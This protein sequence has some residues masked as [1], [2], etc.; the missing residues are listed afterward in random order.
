MHL[1]STARAKTGA[2]SQAEI[3]EM[4]LNLP[5]DEWSEVFENIDVPIADYS[6]AALLSTI[7]FVILPG[8]LA[9]KWMTYLSTTL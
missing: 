2:E 3:I 4:S 6:F 7:F 5:V 8:N 1:N 9:T